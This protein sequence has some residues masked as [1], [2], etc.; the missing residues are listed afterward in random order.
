MVLIVIYRETYHGE[1][2]VLN[3]LKAM[4]LLDL[5]IFRI[6]DMI[7]TRVREVLLRKSELPKLN[8]YLPTYY[9]FVRRFCELI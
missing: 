9:I 4:H 6:I 1:D 5:W 7:L 2:S 8:M 3:T